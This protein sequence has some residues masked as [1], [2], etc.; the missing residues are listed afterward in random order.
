MNLT[1]TQFQMISFLQGSSERKPKD[2]A[3][4]FGFGNGQNQAAYVDYMGLVKL[5][6]V[7]SDK[8]GVW[9]TNEGAKTL[10]TPES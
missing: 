1:A 3:T 8:R 2:L 9:L 5:G 6:F 4:K 10:E 7:A